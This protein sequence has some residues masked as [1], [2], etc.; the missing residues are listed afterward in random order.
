MGASIGCLLHYVSL[1]EAHCRLGHPSLP[2]LKKLCPQFH[3]KPSIDC[4]SCHFAKH[5]RSSLSPRNNKRADFAF[6]LVHSDVWRPCLIVSKA[7]FRYFVTFVDDFSRMTWIYFMKNRFEV[8]SHFSNFCVEIK[9]QF[10]ASI[11]ILRSDNA[12]EFMSTSF[13][14]YMNHYGILHQSLCVDTP[15]QNGVAERKNRHLLETARALLFQMKV[16]KQF[17]ADAVSTASFLINHMPSTVLNGD[18]PYGVLFHNEPLFPLEPRVS[19]RTCYVRDVRPHVTKLDP[20]ALKCVFLDI[21]ACKKAIGATLR[22]LT[23]I[24]CQ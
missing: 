7:G 10:N 14:N 18:I 11:H 8:F 2:V 9:T 16:T 22:H 6:Q 24:W 21:L 15:S 4:E 3:N 17:W 12:K 13:Q 1:F 20:K 23:D 5:Y 19:G